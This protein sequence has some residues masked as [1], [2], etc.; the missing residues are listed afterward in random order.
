MLD[1]FI[2]RKRALWL[3]ALL[4]KEPCRCEMRDARCEMWDLR[5]HTD[6][7][8]QLIQQRCI[9]WSHIRCKMWAVRCETWDLTSRHLP[10][11]SPTHRN[12]YTPTHPTTH[13]PIHPPLRCE[14]WEASCEMLL[15]Q[16]MQHICVFVAV[17]S[18]VVETTYLCLRCSLISVSSLQCG[19]RVFVLFLFQFLFI[20]VGEDFFPAELKYAD[21]LRCSVLCVSSL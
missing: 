7:F 10:T 16:L 12:T 13:P 18:D 20:I 9:S 17:W 8:D 6:M 19:I 2:F 11:H 4:R 14:M 1:L 21:F 5:C 15:Y 3:A